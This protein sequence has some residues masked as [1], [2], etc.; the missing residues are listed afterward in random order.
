MPNTAYYDDL[1]YTTARA[2]TAVNPGL[3]DTLARLLVAQAKHET[4]NYTHRFFTEGNNAFGYS[5]VGSRYQS[6]P[7]PVADNGKPIGYYSSIQDSVKEL[8]D[9]IY[10]RSKEGKFPADLTM[11]TTPADYAA[12]LKSVGYYGATLQVYTAALTRFFSTVAKGIGENVTVISIALLVFL[13]TRIPSV[14]KWFNS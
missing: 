2:A 10:R 5:Y 8:V 7:G 9:Y 11:I 12:L 1:I 6:G 14:R 4:G 3:P 13:L